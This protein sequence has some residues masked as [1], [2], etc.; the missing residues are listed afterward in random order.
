MP[1]TGDQRPGFGVK[2]GEKILFI[3][4]SDVDPLVINAFLRVLRDEKKCKVD[5]FQE[6]GKRRMYR[7]SEIMKLLVESKPAPWMLGGPEWT[8]EIST[9]QGY[10]KVIGQI[11]WEENN[12][13]LKEQNPS[14]D[15]PTRE[16]LASPA[17]VYPE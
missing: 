10:D 1:Y 9:T 8:R 11:F 15:W 3:T 6:Q 14:P 4:S 16:Q 7:T 2:G 17:V 13:R 5:L 12:L